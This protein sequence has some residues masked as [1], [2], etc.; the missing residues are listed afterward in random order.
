MLVIH[1]TIETKNAMNIITFQSL[2]VLY[3][4]YDATC[5]ALITLLISLLS[6]H[7]PAEGLH[8][9][10]LVLSVFLFAGPKES[11]VYICMNINAIVLL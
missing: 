6:C 8:F 2:S 11:A 4:I 10:A 3:I 7:A 9:S 1:A 5:T